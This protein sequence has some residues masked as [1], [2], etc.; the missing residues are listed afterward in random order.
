MNSKDVIKLL[1]QSG[2]ILR[3]VRGSHHIYHHP[4][5]PGHISVPHPKKDLGIGIVNKL[6]KQAGLK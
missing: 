4:D 5:R 6:L 2:W 3:G 1:T